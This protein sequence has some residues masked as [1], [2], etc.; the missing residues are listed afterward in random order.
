MLQ[1]K[2]TR[3]FREALRLSLKLGKRTLA[4]ILNRWTPAV[5]FSAYNRTR[6]ADPAK[7]RADLKKGDLALR[8]IAKRARDKGET[9][10][11]EE[12]KKRAR[13]MVSA[14][15]RSVRYVAVGF[16]K[17]AQGFGAKSRVADKINPQSEA[18]K[19]YGEKAT[20]GTLKAKLGNNSI[21]ADSIALEALNGAILEIASKE[22]AYATKKLQET[23]N[24]TA[25][26]RRR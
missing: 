21:A 25:G 20:P 16:L 23:F 18:A 15:V 2:G 4:E 17:A 14:R 22:K 11:K 9:L 5:C 26:R 10:T 6:K 24:R 1:L 7:I 13:K 8:I 19:S 3:E 12:V